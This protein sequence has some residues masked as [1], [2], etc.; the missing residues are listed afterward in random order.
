MGPDI[1][2]LPDERV[3]VICTGAQ[4]EEFAALSRM[5]RDEFR[6]FKLRPSDK[7]LM[8][9]TAIPG[10]EKQVFGLIDDLIKKGIDV[11]TN[12]ELD[13]HAS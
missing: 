12:N 7:V 13:I 4:G 9:A 2:Q 1:E 3:M 6:D 8:S 11:V 10:N 5:A